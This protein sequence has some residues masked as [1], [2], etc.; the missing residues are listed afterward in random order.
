MDYPSISDAHDPTQPPATN[1]KTAGRKGRLWDKSAK[2]K[3]SFSS[4]SPALRRH[5]VQSDWMTKSAQT[6]SPRH[7]Q[8]MRTNRCKGDPLT[9][10]AV[11]SIFISLHMT[12]KCTWTSRCPEGAHNGPR[13]LKHVLLGDTRHSTMTRRDFRWQWGTRKTHMT[14]WRHS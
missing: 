2:L 5:V 9:V 12:D 13:H 10:G 7:R 14:L 1:M 6:S 4:R 11:K 3:N 8:A